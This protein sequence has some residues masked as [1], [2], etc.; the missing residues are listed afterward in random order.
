MFSELDNDL[1]LITGIKN[2]LINNEIKI[3]KMIVIRNIFGI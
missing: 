3:I 2:I 1:E